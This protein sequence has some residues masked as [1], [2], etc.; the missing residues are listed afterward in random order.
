MSSTVVYRGT[1]DASAAVRLGSSPM[2]VSASDEDHVLRVYN[3]EAPGMPA[4][5]V[6]LEPFL[7]PVEPG[8]EPDIEGAALVGDRI[9]WVTSHGRNKDREEQESRQRFFATSVPTSHDNVRI[10]PI[11]RPYTRLL[12]DLVTT[13]ELDHLGL[14]RAA[15]LAPEEPGGLN[16]EGLAPTPDGRLLIGF[17]NPVPGGRALIVALRNPSELIQPGNSSAVISLAGHLDL[18]GRG[19]RALEF[20]PES[21]MFLV[22]AGAFDDSGDFRIYK[23]S[24]AFG[25]AAREVPVDVGDCRPEELI[26]AGVHGRTC[27]LELMSDDGDRDVEGKKCKKV[28]PEKRS[29]R[30]LR[31]TIEL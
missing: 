2:F 16:L 30:G 23:W 10:K 13:P 29:F 25:D 21:G 24:G 8:K 11:G 7:K 19:I 1:C 20:V 14:Q 6:D 12:R 9:Y 31:T 17:R 22:V 4:G 27:D 18:G 5:A 26:V 28:K 15:T 3:R